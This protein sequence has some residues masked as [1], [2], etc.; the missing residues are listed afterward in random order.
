[1]GKSRGR[2]KKKKKKSRFDGRVHLDTSERLLPLMNRFG[3]IPVCGMISGYNAGAL[4]G[5]A[6][7]DGPDKFPA[8]WRTLLVKHLHAQGFIISNHWDLFS[9]FLGEVAPLVAAG[10]IAYLEDIAD[11]LANAPHAFTGMLEGRNMGKQIVKL[12]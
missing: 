8:F 5:A 12:I 9:Q 2:K 4:G 10:D 3:R 6:G 11:G 1:M 7:G